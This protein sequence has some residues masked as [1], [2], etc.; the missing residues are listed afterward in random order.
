[1][2][3]NVIQS[4]VIDAPIDRVWA[5]LRD[6]NSHDR[7]HPAV[8]RSRMENDVAGD[9]VG[10]VRRFS[11]S[12][13]SE[14]REQL[15]SHSDREYTFTYCI[16]D[17]PL[18]LFDYMASVRLKPVTDGNQTFWDWRAQFR[19]PDDR[20]AEL[21]N[22]V[23]QKVYQ[24]GFG[25]LRT[26]LADQAAPPMPPVPEEAAS[27]A[28]AVGGEHLP[29]RAVVVATAGGPEVMSL[30]DVTIS[31]PGPQQVRIRQ[32][33]IAVNYLDLKHRRGIA[34]GFDFPGT[35]IIDYKG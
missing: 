16:L 1:M 15:L 17:S 25:G 32:T 29:S 8:A 12:D 24:A 26:F 27:V 33:A 34:A 9:V 22:L 7:W 14:L 13:G 18:P 2:K 11:L 4:A 5:V 23:G 30:N 31:A 6:F 21:K 35:P 20:A 19:T 28:A 3:I 10:G